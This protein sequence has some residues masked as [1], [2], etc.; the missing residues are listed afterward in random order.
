LKEQKMNIYDPL[1]SP[2]YLLNEQVARQVFEILPDDGPVV[3]IMDR[4]GHHWPNDS[5]AF[6]KFHISDAYLNELAARIDD[7]TEP[8]IAQTDKCTIVATELATE[9]TRCGYIALIMKQDGPE[10]AI[11]NI[12]L[13]E[14]MTGLVNL[15]ARLIEKNVLLYELQNRII[16]GTSQY[17]QREPAL[18]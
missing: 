17:V 12:G 3:L 14:T 2:A 15:I 6:A 11:T 1:V 4:S 18:N 8:L 10:H 9:R 16:P 13:L 5:E 7:G